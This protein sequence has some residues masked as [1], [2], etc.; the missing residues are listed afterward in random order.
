[1]ID[2]LTEPIFTAQQKLPAI[3]IKPYLHPATKVSLQHFSLHCN[4]STKMMNS[5]RNAIQP[6]KQIP[7]MISSTKD[8][9]MTKGRDRCCCNLLH[10]IK[11]TLLIGCLELC[12]FSYE[13][14]STAHQFMQT[15]GQYITSLSIFLFGVILA[16]IAVILLFLAIKIST[17][18]LLVPHILMQAAAVCVLSSLCLFCLFTLLAGTSLDFRLTSRGVSL[19]KK[20]DTGKQYVLV[21]AD[22]SFTDN[23]LIANM[24]DESVWMLIIVLAAFFHLQEKV[25]Q[26]SQPADG[27]NSTTNAKS[28]T[29]SPKGSFRNKL[30]TDKCFSM[31]FNPKNL[32]ARGETGC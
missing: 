7:G 3:N 26:K 29:E 20:F 17:P 12:F 5:K 31:E 30:S 11:A 21:N 14:F 15:G 6:D 25:N 10:V 9:K 16:I 2:F 1:M 8:S 4:C 13:V 23:S 22:D 28:S 32:P 18:Y 19:L 27:V 24:L